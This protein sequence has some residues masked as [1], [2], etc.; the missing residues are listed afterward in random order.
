MKTTERIEA[1]LRG[2]LSEQEQ[3]AFD[4]LR[5]IDPELDQKVVAHQA[6]MNQLKEY[7]NRQHLLSE[8]NAIHELLDIDAIKDEVLPKR[9]FIKVLWSKYRVN[10]A[11]AAS[12]AILAAFSTLL[13]TGYFYKTNAL[14]SDNIDLRRKINIISNIQKTQSDQINNIKGASNRITNPGQYGGTG[15]ALTSDGYLV[16]SYHVIKDADSVYIQNTDGES[17]KVKTVYAHPQ[18]DI[19]ILQ[20]TD[21]NFKSLKALPYTFKK[22]T[23]DL[24]EHVFTIGYP[25]EEFVFNE[26]YVS[27]K[28]GYNGDTVQYQ[29]DIPANLGNSG[30]PLLDTKGNVIGV[31][32]SKQAKTDGATFVVKSKYLLEALESIPQDSLS[33]SL[34]LNKKNNLSNLSRKDQVKKIQDY[35]YMVKVY[36]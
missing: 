10:A 30:G 25:R 2:E 12:V 18:Y 26:G 36:Q 6:F 27:A 21:P 14:N 3:A 15:F 22:S 4:E 13:S 20:V 1:Y 35:V 24:A 33:K 11:V 8:M 32:R 7:G 16:T 19:A 34:V 28:T 31:I 17:F 5:T 23:S 9:S 29:V